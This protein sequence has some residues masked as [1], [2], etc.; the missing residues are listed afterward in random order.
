MAG[1]V[2]EGWWHCNFPARRKSRHEGW[3]HMAN[4]AEVVLLSSEMVA[5]MYSRCCYT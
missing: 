1:G 5:S 2:D 4:N 3:T